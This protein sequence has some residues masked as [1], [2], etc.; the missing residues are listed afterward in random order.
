M[1]RKVDTI[2]ILDAFARQAESKN[3]PADLI[4]WDTGATGAEVR[5]AIKREAHYGNLVVIDKDGVQVG[6]LT[7]AGR[8][9][10]ARMIAER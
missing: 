3:T 2:T 10:L 6:R 1:S 4:E 8:D 7:D 5:S 9:K